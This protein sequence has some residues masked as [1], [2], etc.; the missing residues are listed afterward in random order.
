MRDGCGVDPQGGPGT[1]WPSRCEGP[2][3]GC[4]ALWVPKPA[5]RGC[6]Y[7]GVFAQRGRECPRGMDGRRRQLGRCEGA[8]LARADG[9]RPPGV[10]DWESAV[11]VFGQRLELPGLK[12]PDRT[13]RQQGRMDLG[14]ED[15]DSLANSRDVRD[16]NGEDRDPEN[17][18]PTNYQLTPDVRQGI[19]ETARSN[20]Q[21]Y[22]R[23]D[24]D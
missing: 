22:T 18:Q 23:P 4:A 14:H 19:I 15:E 11:H 10:G 9:F 13:R 5:E 24:P 12:P 20:I 6:L 3:G 1:H 16:M 2:C 8:A 21:R 17:H 7:R